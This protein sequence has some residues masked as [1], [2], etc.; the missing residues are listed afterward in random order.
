MAEIAQPAPRATVTTEVVVRALTDEPL[1][2]YDEMSVWCQETITVDNAFATFNMRAASLIVRETA[3]HPEWDATTVPPRAK[4]IAAQLAKRSYL[5]PNATVRSAVG[6]LSESTVEDF[7]RTLE[8]TPY[9][10]NQ[11]IEIGGLTPQQGGEVYFLNLGGPD[12]LVTDGTVYTRDAAGT[13]FPMYES[14]D[15][16]AP[17]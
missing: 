16:G 4:L 7:A 9:E 14:G 1:M 5:N 6:P 3:G 11:L 10:R 12:P 2:T 8:L 17:E 15:V 13:L